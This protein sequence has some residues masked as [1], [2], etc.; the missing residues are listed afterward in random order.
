MPGRSG[1]RVF[2]LNAG[3]AAV[4]MLFLGDVIATGR[5]MDTVGIADHLIFTVYGMLSFAGG[6]LITLAIPHFTK[7]AWEQRHL[8]EDDTAAEHYVR[9]ARAL[10]ALSALSF[11]AGVGLVSY[12]LLSTFL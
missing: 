6:A 12:A 11:A 8:S 10:A 5:Y 7:L 9:R 1:G 3:G 4:T 2:V